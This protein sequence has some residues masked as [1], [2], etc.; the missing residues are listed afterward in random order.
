MEQPSATFPTLK[1][2]SAKKVS[3][4]KRHDFLLSIP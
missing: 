1:K 2:K 3:L 4:E